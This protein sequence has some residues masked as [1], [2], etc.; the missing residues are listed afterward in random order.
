MTN[1]E[2]RLVLSVI[3]TLTFASVYATLVMAPVLTQISDEFGVSTGTAGLVAAAYGGPGIVTSLLIG[4]YSDRFGRK[5][6]LVAGAFVMG[7]FTIVSA[8]A[9]TFELLIAAR[10]IAGIGGSLIF[11]NANALIGDLFA[12]RERGR[13]MSTVIGFNT[14]A[15]V[16]GVPVAGVVAEA[17]SWRVSVGLVGVIA[18]VAGIGLA[19]FLRPART[20]I[21]ADR[22]WGMY[23][24]I[25]SNPSA[26]FAIISSFLGSL[27]WFTWITYLVVFFQKTYGLSEGTASTYSLTLG[28]GVLVGSQIGGRVGDRIGH[29]RVVA[30]TIVASGLIL[31]A[32]TAAPPP[33]IAAAA[34][35]LLLSAVIGARFATNTSLLTEQVPEARGTLF[36]FSSATASLSIVVGAAIGGFFVDTIG[37]AAIGV[38]CMGA[39]LLSSVIVLAFVREEPMEVDLGVA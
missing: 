22:I 35:N 26:V 6:F 37:F 16:I 21:N 25:L 27:Y 34:M 13:A 18:I 12:Y 4:P 23:R 19:I 36:A 5:R 33:L 20:N 31:L 8:L 2:K 29:R 17:T 39:A 14:M 24:L 9:P 30:G 7:I 28:L 32:L 3:G 15:S 38:F 10:A 11:P 1:G